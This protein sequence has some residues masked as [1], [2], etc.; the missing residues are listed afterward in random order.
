M[1]SWDGSF[2]E[3]PG[4][5]EGH[6]SFFK[7]KKTLRAS[8]SIM[9]SEARSEGTLEQAA[10]RRGRRKGVAFI[11]RPSRSRLLLRDFSRLPL[12]ESL[13][14]GWKKWQRLGKFPGGEVG[15]HYDL[16]SRALESL[17]LSKISDDFLKMP[18]SLFRRR[19]S[20]S[21]G[22]LGDSLV[23]EPKIHFRRKLLH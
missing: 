22:T 7:K 21:E 9:A 16:S 8:S 3:P 14:A 10:K 19:L 17:G 4:P 23:K 12:M 15:S 11:P 20:T 13:L 6:C 2:F 1:L 5:N 18:K